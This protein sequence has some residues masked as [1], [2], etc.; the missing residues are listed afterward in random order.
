MPLVSDLLPTTE[1]LDRLMSEAP[2]QAVKE[3]ADTV[4]KLAVEKFFFHWCLEFPEVFQAGGFSCILGNPPW[5]MLQIAEKEFFAARDAEIATAQNAS[6]RKGLIQNLAHNN[7][8]LL[9]AFETAKYDADAQNRFIRESDRFSL[10]AVGKINTYSIFSETAKK[11]ISPTGRAGIIVPTG[12]ATDDTCKKFFSDLVKRQSI[13]ALV[14]FENSAPL[15]VGVHR[16]YKFSLLSISNQPTSQAQFSFFLT[17]PRQLEDKQRVFALT[18]QD[19]ALINPN[20][21]T[22]PV[23]WVDKRE[24]DNKLAGKWD[25]QWLLAFRKVCRA[26][27]ERT[28]IFSLLPIAALGD[29]GQLMILDINKADLVACLQAN[30]SSL[31]FDFVNRQKVGGVNFNFFIVK[32][33]PVLPPESYTPQ[34]IE[35]ISS[36]VLELVYTAWDMQPFASGMG[37]QGAPFVWN[38]ERRAILR[39]ELDAKYAKLYGLTRDELRYI[40]DPS[41]VYGAEFPSETFR[42]LKSKEMKEYGE[43]RTQRLVLAAWDLLESGG[44]EMLSEV[45]TIEDFEMIAVSSEGVGIRSGTV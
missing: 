42:V 43:Y 4:N 7:P 18:P 6:I 25:K 33:L 20:T 45:K 1:T 41:D 22:S 28:A 38:P 29:S 26:T 17:H 12:I 35:F 9:Q 14:D 5:E 19:I 10:T 3:I 34:D 8:E 32:Q 27:D 13:A 44:G 24:V 37:Y 2:S 16:S 39:A 23:Y 31:V 36:R 30:L 21:L 40:L 11:L 15:F